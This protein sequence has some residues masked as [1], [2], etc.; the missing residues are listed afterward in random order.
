[1]IA[2]ALKNT[3]KGDMPLNEE[4]EPFL[5]EDKLTWQKQMR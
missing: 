2:L 3:M 4:I 1:M 5:Y